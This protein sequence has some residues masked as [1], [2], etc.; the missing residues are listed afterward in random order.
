MKV[1]HEIEACG[2]PLHRIHEIFHW[3]GMS[4]VSCCQVSG[5]TRQEINGFRIRWSCVLDNSFTI[6]LTITLKSRLPDDATWLVRRL[7]HFVFWFLAELVSS[8]LSSAP[9]ASDLVSALFSSDLVLSDLTSHLV[10]SDLLSS[11]VGR[12][13]R[14][15]LEGFRFLC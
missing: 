12:T 1:G 13:K 3:N 11:E 2:S 15:L 6:T 10:F 5:V 8:A 9:F 7:S 4:L 14:H